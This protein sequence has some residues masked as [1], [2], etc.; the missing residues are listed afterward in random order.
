[1]FISSQAL[2]LIS[3]LTPTLKMCLDIAN[4]E[5]VLCFGK[6]LE[7]HLGVVDLIQKMPL[8]AG[9]PPYPIWKKQQLEVKLLSDV[10][11]PK[12]FF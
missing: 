7:V 6:T 8:S 5:Q 11:Y 4:C 3:F 1:M 9:T 12:V 2:A 10:S